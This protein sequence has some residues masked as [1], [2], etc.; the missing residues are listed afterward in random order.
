MCDTSITSE[1]ESSNH[2]E[3]L[4]DYGD[5]NVLGEPKALE[6]EISNPTAISTSYDVCVSSF[7]AAKP[8]TP[9]AQPMP[10]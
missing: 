9:P 10:G 1:S 4:L 8:P 7:P 2:D 5:C 6:L 3:L